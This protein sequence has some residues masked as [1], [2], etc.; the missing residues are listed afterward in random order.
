MAQKFKSDS[1]KEIQIY[2]INVD[3]LFN[4]AYITGI[5]QLYGFLINS[6]VAQLACMTVDVQ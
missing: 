5:T 6:G 4:L 2:H 3:I 1:D